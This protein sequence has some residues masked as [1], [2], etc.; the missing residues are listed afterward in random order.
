MLVSLLNLIFNLAY[1]V[2]NIAGWLL[3][4][5]VVMALIIPQN[6]YTLLIGKYVEPVL[7]PVRALL[8]R[9]IPKLRNVRVDFSPIALWLLL[10]VA[11]WLLRLLQNILL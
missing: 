1:W 9:L 6:K 7:S 2:L 3:L 4:I 5:Y 10:S 11:E 8:Y